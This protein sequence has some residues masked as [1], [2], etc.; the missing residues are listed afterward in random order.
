MWTGRK[1]PFGHTGRLKPHP[2]GAVTRRAVAQRRSRASGLTRP[3]AEA[4]SGVLFLDFIPSRDGFDFGF[5][6]RRLIH[7]RRRSYY[8]LLFYLSSICKGV[9]FAR[10]RGGEG[11]HFARTFM[12]KGGFALHVENSAE[13][14]KPVE[15][16]DLRA[17]GALGE[18]ER[19]E[20]SER[21]SGAVTGR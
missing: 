14:H 1:V 9:H 13:S 17:Q 3:L 8:L 20:I 21:A 19:L 6:I 11:V 18:W 15:I 10:I 5:L 7:S 12:E 4:L 2:R 16:G